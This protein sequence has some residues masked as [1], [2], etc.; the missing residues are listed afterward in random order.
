MLK[1][2][3][4]GFIEALGGGETGTPVAMSSRLGKPFYRCTCPISAPT[5]RR[6]LLCLATSSVL[7]LMQAGAGHGQ[8]RMVHEPPSWAPE[9][10]ATYS[11]EN[12]E[13]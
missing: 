2:A 5:E 1:Y 13:G 10:A 6:F 9:R 8:T 4:A 7:S 3:A 11:F 12:I